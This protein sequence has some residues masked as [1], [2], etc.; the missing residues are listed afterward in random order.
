MKYTF[1][2]LA[3]TNNACVG[4]VD[5][6][7]W[8][9]N[10]NKKIPLQAEDMDGITTLFRSDSFTSCVRIFLAINNN[11]WDDASS[12]DTLYKV[13]CEFDD[14]SPSP[15]CKCFYFI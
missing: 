1:R 15:D 10:Q 11:R 7:Y 3:C 2:T 4:N 13:V 8:N 14:K 12:C 6:W 5:L 9:G